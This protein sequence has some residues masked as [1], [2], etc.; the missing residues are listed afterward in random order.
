ML[1]LNSTPLI[2]IIIPTYNSF[3]P[4]F[5]IAIESLLSQCYENWEAV[6]VND[7]S[8]NKYRK[9]LENFINNINDKRIKLINLDRNMGPSTARNKGIGF[10]N[11]EL[12]TFLDADDLLLP[13][14]LDEIVNFFKKNENCS[15]AHTHNILY[16]NI[17][18]FIN[19]FA[20]TTYSGVI[21]KKSEKV[22]PIFPRLAFKK[23]ILKTIKYNEDLLSSEDRDL[24]LQILNNDLFYT[25]AYYL[26]NS[27]YVYRT[28]PSGTRGRYNLK[29]IIESRKKIIDSFKNGNERVEKIIN[30]WKNNY[31]YFKYSDFIVDY[32]EYGLISSILKAM[33]SKLKVQEKLSCS[34]IIGLVLLNDITTKYLYVD[35][36]YIKYLFILSFNGN[37]YKEIRKKLL[38]SLENMN[39]SRQSYTYA[40]KI[41]KSIL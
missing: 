32:Y 35:L 15:I 10:S 4:F 38:S 16:L 8:T 29:R 27:G 28:Y 2:S 30:I 18:K 1:H 14:H 39:S 41:L 21:S 22:D 9:D 37:K 20:F 3:F 36:N 24:S 13:W 19:L 23:D 12:I 6:V 26:P 33:K 17:Y 34:F 31:K 25:K 11:G 40:T 5:E 7:G